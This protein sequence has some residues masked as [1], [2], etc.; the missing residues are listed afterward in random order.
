MVYLDLANHLVGRKAHHRRPHRPSGTDTGV[1][2]ASITNRIPTIDS[3][4]PT[5]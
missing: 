5:E 4:V 1:A 2:T 3:S